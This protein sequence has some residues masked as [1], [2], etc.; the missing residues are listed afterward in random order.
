MFCDALLPTKTLPKLK[1]DGLDVS[2]PCT[3]VPLNEIIAGDPGALLLMRMLPA[4]LPV[5]AGANWAVK[6][7]LDP[8]LIDSG[9]LRPVRRN[10]VP[11]AVA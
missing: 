2:E 10:P 3:P 5:E 6:E 1:L 4:A 7:T 8:G 11:A 9:T